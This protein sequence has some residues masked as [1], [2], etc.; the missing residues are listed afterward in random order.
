[1]I[2][3]II[4]KK[5]N[6]IY[7]NFN[8]IL[9]SLLIIFAIPKIV[10]AND[11]LFIIKGNNYTD[12]NVIISLLENIPENL[13]EEYSNEII[14]ILNES[15]LFSEVSVKFID[16]KYNIIVNEYPSIRKI[17]F[18]NNERLKDDE[19]R[20]IANDLGLANLN[21]IYLNLFIN[22]TKKIYESYGYN[23]IEIE[24][25]EKYN[26]NNNTADL[27]F[28]INEGE[29][30]KINKIII[31]GNNTVL[32]E[33]IKEIIQSKTRSIVN[34]FANNNYKPI[35]I[36]RD[37]FTIINYYKNNG[38]LDVNVETKIEYLETN[39]VNIYFII[40]EGDIYLL[41]SLE[42]IDEKNILNSKI[43]D[44]INNE[45]ELFLL[46][47]TFFSIKKIEE[48]EKEISSI[49][50]NSGLD[51]FEI[52]LYEKKV[53][54][55]I[56][57]LFQVN[58]IKP[59][60]TNQINIIGNS[61]T[62][63]YVIRRELDII[64]GD[65]IFKNQIP[66]IREKL[67]SLNLF[68][69]VI[70]KEEVNDDDTVDLIIQVEEKQTG[71]FNAGI[72]LGTLD[73]FAIVTGLRENNFYGT[74]RS[75]DFLVNTS[76]DRNQFKL[77]TRDRLSYENDANINYSINFKQEDF[78][79]S[80]SY[81]LDTLSSGIGIDYQLNNNFYH[82]I[83]LEYVLKDY[84]IT[85]STSVSNSI[86]N[87]SG[88]NISYL[89]KNNLRFSTLNPGFVSKKGNFLNFNNTIETPT[90]SNNGFIRNILSLKKYYNKK[91]SIFAMQ[92]KLGNIFSLNNNDI[93]TDDK[94]SLGGRWLRGF[95]NY[96][97]GPRNSRTSY[98]GGN[99][100][101][102]TKFDYSYELTKN[103]NFP[104]YINFFNDYGLLW[105]NKTTPTNSDNSL[106]SSV[107]FGFKY[108]SPIGP[109]GFTWGFPLI[110][111][112]YDIKRMFLFS[113]GNLD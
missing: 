80:S 43:I 48:F 3:L 24:Y 36:E 54:K 40:T 94:F 16:N 106:R 89:I 53:N 8:Y 15:N 107:G 28:I 82:N 4:M 69:S 23:N 13:D 75:L 35:K 22:E 73:G 56:E 71:T 42:I 86:L 62:L 111:K 96:G 90:S 63:D 1:M 9:I 46:N 102:A 52:N 10:F 68:E 45:I 105:E 25:Y 41:S 60:Y 72:S 67:T 65:P 87:S 18:E 11:N 88:T 92:A 17:Y 5:L 55:S 91:N 100:L 44:L 27:Y 70:V 12:S 50:I 112:E 66:K 30:T 104:F 85:N 58:S 78:S 103:S 83:E 77:V 59:K 38:F 21:N 74:G 84:S 97:A 81:K 6:K 61:R 7:Q 49:I 2:L 99:N 64:E 29:I 14:K 51:Y 39:K 79:K 31:N 98:V 26:E 57:I 110:E 20:I 19:L 113:V 47:Q 33:D 95:D 34:I 109:I 93:L 37:K 32:T 76:D 101:A 108:Y